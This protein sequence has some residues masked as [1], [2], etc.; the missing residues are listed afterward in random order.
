[1]KNILLILL[2]FWWPSPLAAQSEVYIRYNHLGYAPSAHKVLVVHS[3]QDISQE[4]WTL[5]C[6]GNEVLGGL[7]GESL[8]GRTGHTSFEFNYQID[9]SA[10]EALG[11][12]ELC[13]KSTKVQFSIAQD[14][15]SFIASDV[16]RYFRVL[17]SGT[18]QTLDHKL[19]HRGDKRCPIHRRVNGKNHQWEMTDY[20][21]KKMDVSGG[22]YDAGDYLKFTLT[23]A[24]ASYMML[25][26]YEINPELFQYQKYSKT[27]LNDL[28]DEATIGLEFLM[29]VS[30]DSTEFIIQVGGHKDHMQG[31]RLPEHDELNGFRECYSAFSPTQMAF[32]AAAL[33]LGAQL[34]EEVDSV[35]AARYGLRAIQIDQRMKGKEDCAWVKQGWEEFYND[36]SADDNR[37]L[38]ALELYK[39]TGHQ[40][41]KDQAE[42][43]AAAAKQSYWYSWGSVHA[44]AHQKA[45][46]YLQLGTDFGKQD[47]SYFHGHSHQEGN[48][49]RVPHPYTWSS[50]Y[51]FMGVANNF[52]LNQLYFGDSTFEGGFDAVLNY[53]LGTNNWGKA[54]VVSEQIPHSVRNVY[55]QIYKL[56]PKL[57]PTGAIAEGPGDRATHERLKTYFK[58]PDTDELEK[59]NTSKAV[60]YDLNTN[61]QTMETTL[62]GLSEG[63]LMMAI[64]HKIH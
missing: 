56:K 49:W 11:T 16:L 58:I 54:F 4:H 22:W 31:D 50:L 55:S 3:V 44:M 8:A 27:S 51:S 53:T 46:H 6:S 35:R 38:A 25:S 5:T 43:F 10:L 60:F 1:M 23:T 26:A 39:L 61:F 28:L 20:L 21:P 45:R 64:A 62:V 2:S 63:L 41:Y 34:F 40:T 30:A 59:F 9:L 12:Y 29:K 42:V 32:S 48:L 18:R 47:L 33:A 7:V 17:R 52:A 57:Y 19:S 15:Y 13:I 37:L 24:Y 36:Q 14:P